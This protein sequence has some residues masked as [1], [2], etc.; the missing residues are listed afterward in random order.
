M[1]TL[2]RMI[3]KCRLSIS[4][5]GGIFGG[6]HCSYLMDYPKLKLLLFMR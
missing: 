3:V 1:D 2:R 4:G 5:T 6:I